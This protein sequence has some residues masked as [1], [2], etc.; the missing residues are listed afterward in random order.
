MIA[1]VAIGMCITSVNAQKGK[2]G[3]SAGYNSMIAKLSIEGDSDTE[4]VGGFYLGL[5]TSTDINE[6]VDVKFELQFTSA[7]SEGD[8]SNQLLLPILLRY[9][10]APKFQLLVGPQL[11]YIVGADELEEDILNLFGLGL[12]LG[13]EINFTDSLFFSSRYS[14]GLSNRVDSDITEIIDMDMKVSNFQL[15]LGYTF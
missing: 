9:E 13:A 14:F 10:V 12:A 1:F 2:F 15:G 6:T 3:I 8:T 11:E 5:F 4:S 7:S